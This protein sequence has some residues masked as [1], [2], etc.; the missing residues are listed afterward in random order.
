MI[1]SRSSR[2]LETSMLEK[3]RGEGENNVFASFLPLFAEKEDVFS[4]SMP[5]YLLPK[6][7]YFG[8]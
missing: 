1:T 7:G 8:E 2:E 4:N 5:V 3:E 6:V